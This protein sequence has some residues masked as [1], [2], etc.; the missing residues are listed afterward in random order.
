MFQK[1][2]LKGRA[3]M[4]EVSIIGIDLAKHRVFDMINVDMLTS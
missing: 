3:S 1:A 4:S 2:S